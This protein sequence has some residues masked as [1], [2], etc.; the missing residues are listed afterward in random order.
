MPRPHR[1][2]RAAV[3]A[4]L[5]AALAGCSA[6]VVPEPADRTVS[7]PEPTGD[8]VL[9]IGTLLP[10][11]GEAAVLGPAMVAAAELAARDVDEAGGVGGAPIELVHRD[12]G[13]AAGD[14][15][16]TA[17]G[18][19]VEDG[20]DVVIGPASSVLVE[21]VLP[22]AVEAGVAVITP[23]ATAPGLGALDDDGLL[24]RT[25]PSAGLQGSALAK[26][27]LVEDDD[28]RVALV[29]QDDELGRELDER[30]S[31]D[32]E[33]AGGALVASEPLDDGTEELA[34]DLAGREPTAVVLATGGDQLERTAALA[35]ALLAHGV[36]AEQLWFTA[37]N[38]ADYGPLVEPGALEGAHGLGIGAQPGESF[39]QRLREV[40]PAVLG[41]A[42][43]AETYDAVLLAALA[44][45][46]AG[47]DGGASIATRL[48]EASSGG[49]ECDSADA[50][51][52]ALAD[53]RDIDY[54]G[55][56]GPL[57]LD[58]AGESQRGTFGLHVYD[59]SGAPQR[60]GQFVS[61]KVSA[62]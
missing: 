58:A 55:F 15:L 52:E 47:D 54:D 9:T 36:D 3:P 14:Q 39:V 41:T 28:A 23:S 21:R 61:G 50:C 37:G 43:A 25:V 48:A 27:L 45:A 33:A 31:L 60:S 34:A 38:L 35:T 26:R 8:G 59:A 5:I 44:A 1:I 2:L 6:E 20:V 10:T 56:S 32:L 17:F 29:R 57:D 24:A 16:E 11:S 13:D 46:M 22:L 40:D 51:L 12:S 4:L 19:F 18:E 30:L 62:R 49:A 42:F 7:A 53:G